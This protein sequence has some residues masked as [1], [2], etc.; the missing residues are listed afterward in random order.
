MRLFLIPL[1]LLGLS[2]CS[3]QPPIRTLAAA[4]VISP[5]LAVLAAADAAFDGVRGRFGFVVQRAEW[6]GT[7]LFLNSGQFQKVGLSNH[8]EKAPL[9][10]DT[11]F[12]QEDV[13][14]AELN[15]WP[16]S[17]IVGSV[18]R[19]NC[20]SLQRAEGHLPRRSPATEGFGTAKF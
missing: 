4:Q 12:E 16:T 13:P 17:E 10:Q 15:S 9:S 3:T 19:P 5:P 2:A 20:Q 18:L 1:L 11:P 7:R 8:G 14:L 6:V